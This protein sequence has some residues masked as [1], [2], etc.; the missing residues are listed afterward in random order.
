[1]MIHVFYCILPE[2]LDD[3][4]YNYFL[5][6]VPAV[7]RN[8][9]VRFRNWEDR[10]HRVLGKL[11]LIKGLEMLGLN[12]YSLDQ[13]KLT[14]LKRPYFDESIDFNISHSGE[15]VVCAISDS[16]K[17]GIDIEEIKDIP[18]TD[19]ADQFSGDEMKN[20]LYAGDSLRSFYGLW[21]K[22]EAFLKAIGTGLYVPLNKVQVVDHKIR[23]EENDWFLTELNLN[24]DYCACLCANVFEAGIE[25]HE[26]TPHEF[27][28]N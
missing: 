2:K 21:T 19:F 10:Q 17:I 8:E 7:F 3:D 12:D 4:S 1:M 22:K 13:L 14:N 23:W 25:I 27:Y 6:Q 16:A 5:N 11:L 26:I 20:I 24:K 15:Y 28:P 9:I 18:L